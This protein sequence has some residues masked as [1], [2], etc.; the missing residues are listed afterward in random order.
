MQITVTNYS[1]VKV[2]NVKTTVLSIYRVELCTFLIPI[3][4]SKVQ[5]PEKLGGCYL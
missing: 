4:Y 5:T 1:N 3:V 2:Y